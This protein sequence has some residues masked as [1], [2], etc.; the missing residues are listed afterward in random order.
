MPNSHDSHSHDS[1][2]P[3][4]SPRGC[5][6]LRSHLAL[7]LL[8]QSARRRPRNCLASLLSTHFKARQT[9]SSNVERNYPSHG[10]SRVQL[11][12]GLS[13]LLHVG[14]AMGRSDQAMVRWLSH[15]Y[16]RPV[17]RSHHRLRSCR[18]AP[19][20]VRWNAITPLEAPHD[21][22]QLH[23]R[24]VESRSKCFGSLL[25]PSLLSS[26]QGYISY[27]QRCIHI[28][29][30]SIL[31]TR[32]DDS[33]AVIGKARMIHPFTITSGLLTTLGAALL[34]DMDIN[35][36]K[37]WYIGA[38]VPF[39]LG[40]GLGNQVPV[41]VLQAFATAEDV[42]ATTG[43]IFSEYCT[44]I[45]FYSSMLTHMAAFQTATGAYFVVAAQSIFA[46][47]MVQNLMEKAKDID[48]GSVLNAGAAELQTLY[49]GSQL[50]EVRDAY[51]VGIKTVFAFCIAV[52][53]A[54]VFAAL[55]VPFKSFQRPKH[56]SWR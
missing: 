30:Y 21:L 16:S 26:C 32:S 46:N 41:T 53:A 48:I 43:I 14:T 11:L 17:P 27:H 34:W 28:A 12:V 2:S 8:D 24:L 25:P 33:G 40:I 1:H 49:T 10:H 19:G 23:L 52:S 47:L 51:M 22:G 5:L 55:L 31:C 4:S 37:A 50:D 38:Q 35:T 9:A 36:S 56:Q 54:T 39:G 20:R 13:Y 6:H 45:R 42:A 15:C 7:V 44:T 3:R 18:V 29:F